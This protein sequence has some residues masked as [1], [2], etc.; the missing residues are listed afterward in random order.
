M[1]ALAILAMGAML[2]IDQQDMHRSVFDVPSSAVSADGRYIAFVTYAQL[3]GADTDK[4]S[5]LYVYD[6][7]RQQ[8]TF[9]SPGSDAID[10]IHPGIS[11]DGRHV[12]YESDGAIMWRDA[13]TDVTRVV[14]QGRQPSIA[15]ND[16]LLY[17]SG[18]NVYIVSPQSPDPRRVSIDMPVADAA[19]LESFS[20]SASADG[21]Y[22][23][24]AARPPFAARRL[25]DTHVF[26]RDI[27]L[28]VTR[29]VGS[30][31]APSM[32]GDGK[33]AAFVDLVSG[34][35]HIVLADLQQ[36]T[37]RVI[38]KSVRRGLA[39]GASVNP[40]ISLDGRFV[41]FQSEANDL[42]PG[43]DFNLL[44]DVFIY[45]R[46]KATI[47]RVS[48][49]PDGVWMEPSVGPTID[50]S[51]G[52]IAFSSRHPTASSDKSNDFD[53]YVATPTPPHP[54]TEGQKIRRFF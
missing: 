33:Y 8:V 22:V 40:S 7:I 2:T 34:L 19:S 50:G 12:V 51:G 54:S 38:T 45:D 23:S 24:F 16:I 15:G 10:C 49:D 5:D 3:A 1:K 53:L 36:G 39:N 52:V 20:A 42:V 46:E 11:A 30:G 6:R 26:V 21:R 18:H 13:Q 47:S 17:T 9:E 31:W 28:N 48:G 4:T 14:G 41:V 37:T 32:S 25:R 44:W 43:D 27:Q 29:R 35:H